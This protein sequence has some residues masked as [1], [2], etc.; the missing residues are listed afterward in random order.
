MRL[1]WIKLRLG[2]EIS[3]QELSLFF[4]TSTDGQS[5]NHWRADKGLYAIDRE[6]GEQKWR[7]QHADGLMDHQWLWEQ[8]HCWFHGW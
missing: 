2:G 1:I 8:S 4:I 6:T 7:I 3:T 5:G